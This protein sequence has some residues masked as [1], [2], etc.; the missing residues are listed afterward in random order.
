MPEAGF[1]LPEL[2]ATRSDPDAARA[3]WADLL[4]RRPFSVR[5]LTA[6]GID[7]ARA[8]DLDGARPYLECAVLVS[9]QRADLRRNLA[10]LELDAGRPAQALLQY[11]ALRASGQLDP[12]LL[13]GV[14]ADQI[15]S[16]RHAN[17]AH[18]LTGCPELGAFSDPPLGEECLAASDAAEAAGDTR[19]ADALEAHGQRTW[20]REHALGGNR[21]AARRSL[22]QALRLLRRT[23]ELGYRRETILTDPDLDGLRGDP[24]FEAL[25]GE[26][27]R[28]LAK[29]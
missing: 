22:R 6:L 1:T 15:F 8:G 29:D 16:A 23:L 19:W 7:L 13:R 27:R 4:I 20:S 14:T 21:A 18:L 2:A 17:A 24:E 3:V 25:V 11:E 10:L 26:V 28:R 12:A 5:A 9:P